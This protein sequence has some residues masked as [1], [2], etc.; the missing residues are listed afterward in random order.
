MYIVNERTKHELERSANVHLGV[1]VSYL[2][3][4]YRYILPLFDC[5]C[6][7]S[8]FVSLSLLR[9]VL[10]AISNEVSYLPHQAS[11]STRP[12]LSAPP[13]GIQA[14]FEKTTASHWQM[15]CRLPALKTLFMPLVY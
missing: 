11:E 3:P 6:T 10:A 7:L 14:E 4:Q 12:R 15:L 1:K 13:G 2:G 5:E 8:A 9:Y